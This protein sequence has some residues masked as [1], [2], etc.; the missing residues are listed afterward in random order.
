MIVV[1]RY[2]ERK[3]ILKSYVSLQVVMHLFISFSEAGKFII[4]E[5]L[6]KLEACSLLQSK[7]RI[8]DL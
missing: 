7:E 3:F 5:K 1:F 6:P 4:M 8:V 2:I